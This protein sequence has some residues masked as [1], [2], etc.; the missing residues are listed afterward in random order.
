MTRLL[1]VLAALLTLHLVFPPR[2]DPLRR[3]TAPRGRHRSRPHPAILIVPVGI[4]LLALSPQVLAIVAAVAAVAALAHSQR[5][6][7][8]RRAAATLRRTTV[9]EALDVLTADLAAGRPPVDALAGAAGIAPELAAVHTAARLGADVPAALNQVA[10]SPGA[11]GLRALAAA[12]QVAEESGAAFAA[13]TER[14]ADSLRADESIHRQTA[15]G[16]AGA[17]ASARI[18]AALPL[19]GLALGYSLGADPIIFLT[20]TPV[21][22]LCLAAGLALTALGLQWTTRLAAT[23]LYR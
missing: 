7:H 5:T 2:P 1:A 21:G 10:R 12:W 6:Q 17:R 22:W 11:E 4:L 20:N 18:L 8:V 23:P 19:F 15:A 14:L 13:L 9:I 3:L 16:L